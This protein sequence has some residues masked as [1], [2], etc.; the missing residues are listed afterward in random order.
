[1]YTWVHYSTDIWMNETFETIQECIEDAKNNIYIL[2][3]SHIYVGECENVQVGGIYL[4]DILCRVEE[5]MHEQVGEVSD[6]WDVYSTSGNYA[7]RQPAYEK[8]NEKL[9]QLVIDYIKEIGEMP[10]F[11]KIVN[12]KEIVID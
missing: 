1:M 12:V 2:P 6:G 10:S 9:R 8:Y 11:Y 4:D 5:D 7:Y 3:G